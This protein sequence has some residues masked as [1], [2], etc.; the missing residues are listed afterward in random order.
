M[1]VLALHD[2]FAKVH[3]ENERVKCLF[4]GIIKN[5]NSTSALIE[6]D[7]LIKVIV[8]L[9][10]FVE[11]YKTRL[12]NNEIET[13]EELEFVFIKYNEKL[14]M[15]SWICVQSRPRKRKLE[16]IGYVLN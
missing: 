13:D 15:L 5:E 3:S 7:G 9:K 4:K 6:A 2:Y 16:L 12:L 11:P 1:S 8:P 10:R 14:K